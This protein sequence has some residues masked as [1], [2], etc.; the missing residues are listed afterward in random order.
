MA[1]IVVQIGTLEVL[2]GGR[3]QDMRQEVSF[4]GEKLAEW[5]EYT[6]GRN[7]SRGVTAT[8]YR[9]D[10]ERL[11]VHV[12]EW[13]R[14]QGEPNEY[15]LTEVQLAD[16]QPGGDFQYLGAEAGLSRPLTLNEALE[17]YQD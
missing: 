16:L 10:D 11:I 7:D 5:T 8:L 14:W 9:T 4:T 13:S 6:D 12:E 15:W 2:N 3:T 17:R 1:E